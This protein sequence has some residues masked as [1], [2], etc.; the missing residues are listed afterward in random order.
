[1]SIFWCAHTL[2]HDHTSG[3]SPHGTNY[4]ACHEILESSHIGRHPKPPL[5]NKVI[6]AGV[7]VLITVDRGAWQET[8]DVPRAS[9][10]FPGLI[11]R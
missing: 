3:D 9:G 8:M 4:G 5:G 1:M 6:G 10:Y 11:V 7:R 2:W